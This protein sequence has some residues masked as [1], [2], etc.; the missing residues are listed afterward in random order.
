M[1]IPITARCK[2]LFQEICKGKCAWD[3]FLSEDLVNNNNNDNTY[4][5]NNN[6]D[7]NYDDNDNNNNSNNNNNNNNIC[8]WI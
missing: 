3:T 6:N 5:D 8:S 4:D 2:L 7:N 1:L